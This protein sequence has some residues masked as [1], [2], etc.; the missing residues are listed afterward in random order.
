[1]PTGFRCRR[2]LAAALLLLATACVDRNPVGPGPTIPD[3]SSSQTRITCRVE[4]A[5]G[6]M[7]CAQP[8]PETGGARGNIIGG[9]DVWV[10]LTSSGTSYDDGAQVLSSTVTVQNL[11][12]QTLGLDS[13]GAAQGIKVYFET[14]PVLTSGTGDVSVANPDG[15]G[16]FTTGMQ[17]YFEYS[18]TLAP[19][20]ISAGKLWQFNVPSTV[21]SFAFTVLVEAPI[22]FGDDALRGAV[23]QGDVDSLWT[24]AGNWA[25]DSVP[26]ANSVVAIPAADSLVG[27]HMPTLTD[28]VS[29]AA[30]R[31]GSGS[32]LDLAAYTLT[33]SGN[34]DAVGTIF[35]G[36]VR[37]TGAGKLLSGNVDALVVAA[38]TALQRATRATGAVSVQDGSLTLNGNALSISVP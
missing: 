24:T 1:M 34:V 4:V 7:S 30:L 13:L 11:L 19:Y 25:G 28:T 29:V 3:P 2:S 9:Q 26:D 31:V 18:E 10:K 16:T 33:S 6:T 20:E 32:T 21:V 23:W 14:G 37:M 27:R 17:P 35:G 8:T 36:T 12:E 15:T 5:S 22:S 38:G